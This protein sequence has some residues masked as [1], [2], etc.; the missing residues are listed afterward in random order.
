MS[1]VKKL[2]TAT[3]PAVPEVPIITPLT[4]L[5]DLR[6]AAKEIGITYWQ[7]YGLVQAGD[8]PV[9]DIGGKFYIRRKTIDRWAERA[10]KEIA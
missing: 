8:L 10:E 3:S 5:L 6:A 9:I 1:N 4:S 2:T 7:I